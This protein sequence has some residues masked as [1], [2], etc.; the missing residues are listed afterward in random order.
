[1]WTIWTHNFLDKILV[2]SIEQQN[3]HITSR[4]AHQ[5]WNQ[6]SAV[7]VW[8]CSN[9][10]W[11]SPISWIQIAMSMW[12]DKPESVVTAYFICWHVSIIACQCLRTIIYFIKF[13][14]ADYALNY[15]LVNSFFSAASSERTAWIQYLRLRWN[16]LEC[17]YWI[18]RWYVACSC[19]AAD[20]ICAVN[21]RHIRCSI[22]SLHREELTAAGWRVFI[23]WECQLRGDRKELTL[24]SLAD[25]LKDCSGWKQ[26]CYDRWGKHMSIVI[27]NNIHFRTDRMRIV[28]LLVL[29]MLPKK[30]RL[31]NINSRILLNGESMTAY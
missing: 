10:S 8:W 11:S 1:M 18:S 17:V 16:S 27:E 13:N 3:I 31:L 15:I 21:A 7:N 29:M 22:D 25:N 20:V 14:L 19:A 24:R 12:I 23:I 30:D 4:F 26:K 28:L 5:L 9:L 2:C 6:T